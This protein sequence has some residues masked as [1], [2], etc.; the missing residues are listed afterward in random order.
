MT[1]VTKCTGVFA[2][3]FQVQERLTTEIAEAI[4]SAIKPQGVGVVIEARHLCMMMRGVE[5]QQPRQRARRAGFFQLLVSPLL[6]IIGE[7]VY[8]EFEGH[9]ETATSNFRMAA[10]HSVILKIS[11]WP[12]G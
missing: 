7:N 10:I 8:E 6:L 3:R 5:K 1:H 11:L 2:R 4:E 9:L 12:I